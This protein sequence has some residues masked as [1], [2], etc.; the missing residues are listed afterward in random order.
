MQMNNISVLAL[1]GLLSCAF[2]AKGQTTNKILADFMLA[3]QS[4]Q[5][6]ATADIQQWRISSQ[7]T[8]QH[9]GVTHVYIQQQYNGVDIKNSVA[10]FS[11]KNAQVINM[12]DRLERNIANRVQA[13]LSPINPESAILAAIKQLDLVAAQGAKLKLLN[14][15]ENTHFVYNNAGVSARD[16][17][18]KLVYQPLPEGEIVLAWDLSIE[19]RKG[20]NYWS[21]RIDAQTG[22]L[23]DKINWTQKCSFHGNTFGKCGN[24]HGNN[25]AKLA[26]RNEEDKNM[27][28]NSQYRIF[29][30]PIE[31]PNHG[32]RSLLVNPANITAS[33]FGWHDINGAMGAEF[34]ITRGNNVYAYEDRDDDDLPGYSPNGGANLIFDFPLNLNQTASGYQDAAISNLFYM[35]NAIHD[36]F[37]GYGFN[38]NSGNFQENNYGRGNPSGADD[39]VLAEA[40]DGGGTNNANFAT[41]EDGLNGRMQMF[42]W[43]NNTGGASSI[44]T[45]N[46]PSVVAGAKTAAAAGFGGA[47]PS[48]PLTA[49]L[50]LVADATAP[51][52]DACEAITN[53]AAINGRIALIDRGL[54]GFTDKVFAAQQAGAIAVIIANNVAGAPFSMGG[55]NNSITIPALMISQ[56]DGNALKAQINA[57]QTVNVTI[58]SLGASNFDL[59]GDFDNGI[60]VHEYGHG[61]STR[62]TG[63]PMN[64]GCLQNAEQMGEGWSDWFALM[65]TQE[66]GDAGADVRG[67]GTYAF[68]EPTTGGG[69][70]NSPYSTSFAV[71]NYTYGRTNDA[72][73]LSEPHGIGFVWAT[74]LWDLNW[75]FCNRYGF[76]PNL[77]T[78][79]G[80]NNTL[81]QL[82]IDGLKLQPCDPGFVDGRDAILRADSINNGGANV[83]MIWEVFARRGLGVNASQGSSLSRSDQTE[84]FDLPTLCQTPVTAPTANFSTANTSSC[85]GTFTFRDAST[86]VP[87]SWSWAFGDGNTSTQRNPTHTYANNGVYVVTLTVGNTLGNSSRTLS[88]T[89]QRPNNLSSVSNATVCLGSIATLTATGNNLN[90]IVWSD[91]NGNRVGTGSSFSTPVITNPS[92]VYTA[93]NMQ[94]FPSQNVGPTNNNFGTGGNHN[95]NFTGTLDFNSS[96]ALTIVST[97]VYSST[98]GVRTISLWDAHGGTGNIIQQINVNI[99]NGQS[100]VTLNLQVPSSGQ[101]SIGTSSANLYRHN[102]GAAYPYSIAGLIDLVG[103]SAGTDFYYY[104]YD[105][106]VEKA[107]CRSTALTATVSAIGNS[108]SFVNNG[109]AVNFS[110]AG[111][112]SGL[113][114]DFGDGN[115]STLTNPSHTYAQAGTYTV[116]LSSNMGQCQYSQVI[117]VN[118]TGVQT[119]AGQAFSISLQPNP[120]RIGNNTLLVFSQAIDSD[121]T[122]RLFAAD[123]REIWQTQAGKGSQSLNIPTTA[124]SAGVYWIQVSDYSPTIKLLIHSPKTIFFY[125]K[126]GSLK[127]IPTFAAAKIIS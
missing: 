18:I 75:A 77:Y 107:A 101:Y 29:P 95:T 30:L 50:I 34:Q 126:V 84:D 119:T 8:D 102:A 25:F 7:Y 27:N 48:S 56:A 92:T 76:D 127:T 37:Y 83:C 96:E 51:I 100:R 24:L 104:F 58:S 68:S 49:N 39:H 98:A 45:V 19:D 12:G 71:N 113:S 69:I 16:I 38:E 118:P 89:V 91:A 17:P 36:I 64:S 121:K 103:S 14:V 42:L 115:N 120:A 65:L 63:G 3:N 105:L 93:E 90:T 52:N 85:N 82:V 21:V 1:C 117:V 41:P 122:V 32:G 10:N 66:T 72:N 23:I 5:G 109:L 110:G 53:A 87:Q 40:Q 79:T 44:L 28:L 4:T 88:V 61:I 108:F 55:S 111:N 67:M 73:D 20:A 47:I 15:V 60:V 11:L 57:G 94:I 54:C 59:D 125:K 112:G 86:N 2:A 80:G 124:L 62:L 78:G 81:L 33:P 74:M 116:T 114:W 26:Q 97:L 123:G 35:N 22:K 6:W 70:R 43:T 106:E 46:S 13:N 9:N 31:S 99:P